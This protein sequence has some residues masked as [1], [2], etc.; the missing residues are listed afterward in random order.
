MPEQQTDVVVIG[1][2]ITGLAAAHWLAAKNHDVRVLESA[3]APGGVIETRPEDGF[4]FEYGPLTVL[5]THPEVLQLIDEAGLTD[6]IV[7]ADKTSSKRFI[8]RDERLRK[9]PSGPGSMM[10]SR[11][12]R[13]RAKLAILREPFIPPA[14]EDANE[15]LAEFVKRRLGNEFLD[16][17]INPMVA[18]VYAGKPEQLEVRAAFPRIWRLEQEYG[19]LIKGAIKGAR[20]R[21]ARARQGEVAKDRARLFSFQRGMIELVEKLASTLGTRLLTGTTAVEVRRENG[22]YAVACV[23]GTTPLRLMARSVVVTVPGESVSRLL[24]DPALSWTSDVYYPPVNQVCFGYRSQPGGMKRRGFGFLVPEVEP[25]DILGTLWLSSL[26]PGRSP[27]GGALLTTYV[28]GARCPKNAGLS[29]GEL[30]DRVHRD[31]TRLMHVERKPDVVR[32]ARYPKAIPQYT[33]GHLK[34]LERLSDFESRNPGLY[35]GSNVVG[36]ISVGDR[37]LFASDLARRIDSFISKEADD[38]HSVSST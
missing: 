5:A 33:M 10:F 23:S 34:R 31:L 9:V 6:R 20:Q 26:F 29:D 18:G 2:G 22:R 28:G 11:L 13:L 7:W 17:A 14:P 32:I 35:V 27:E 12:F 15:S 38:V 3:P 4:L 21:R 30:V 19:S 24:P 25:F 1:A 37:I 16:Y 8:V 36:G